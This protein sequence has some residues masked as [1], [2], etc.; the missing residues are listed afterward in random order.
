MP[1]LRSCAKA[2]TVFT[3]QLPRPTTARATTLIQC[4]RLYS[5]LT[6]SVGTNWKHSSPFITSSIFR[7]FAAGSH[8]I[9]DYGLDEDYKSPKIQHADPE[10]FGLKDRLSV[11]RRIHQALS[12]IIKIADQPIFQSAV[13][14]SDVD[15]A[16]SRVSHTDALSK[17]TF[18]DLNLDS[19]DRVEVLTAVEYEFDHEFSDEDYDRL[20]TIGDLIEEILW[21]PRAGL[22]PEG[23]VMEH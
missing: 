2:V 8:S 18:N 6:Q 3:S 17:L 7:Y 1:S 14:P 23:K 22:G 21:V 11:E 16:A 19:F 5:N 13:P 20:K 12:K 15:I 4:T 9:P 10:V